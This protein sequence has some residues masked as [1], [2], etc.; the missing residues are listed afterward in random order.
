MSSQGRRPRWWQLYLLFP[1]L[2]G[3]FALESNL[4]ISLPEHQLAQLGILFLV[5]SLVHLWLKANSKALSASDELPMTGVTIIQSYNS[6]RGKGRRPVLQLS[7][8]EINGTL[9]DTFD[10]DYID[11]EFVHPID[12]VSQELKKE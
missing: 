9:S 5:Y 7:D 3:L 12:E 6:N 4:K 8:H 10:L 2:V 11:A 1:L